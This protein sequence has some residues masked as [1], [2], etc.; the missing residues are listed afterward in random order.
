MQSAVLNSRKSEVKQLL[1]IKPLLWMDRWTV[2]AWTDRQTYVEDLPVTVS[3]IVRSRLGGL[4]NSLRILDSVA[5]G[6]PL[7]NI[8]SSN[9]K[10]PGAILGKR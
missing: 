9:C 6:K 2:R 4:I 5:R 10:R 3:V 8:S 7:S 1:I